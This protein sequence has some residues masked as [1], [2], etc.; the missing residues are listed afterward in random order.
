MFKSKILLKA[1]IVVASV[2]VAYTSAI[3]FFAIPKV[4]DSIRFIEE[5]NAKELLSKV[6]TITKNVQKDLEQY[7][8]SSLEHRKTEL[9]NLTDTTWS[10]ISAKYEQSKPKNIGSV[11]RNKGENFK[12]NLL[13]FYNKNKDKMDEENLKKAILNYVSMHRH[14]NGT[15]YFFVNKGTKTVMHPIKPSL[16]GKDLKNLKD[17]DGIYF[18]RKFA[19]VS[20]NHGDGIVSYKWENPK[21]KL[22]ENK[23]SYIFT[24]EP[25][26]W[27]IGTGEY[28][29]VLKE[30]LQNEVKELVS[31]LRYADNNYFYIS[32]YNSVLIAH[33][34]LKD[35]DMSDIKDKRGNLIVP[36]MVQ[37]A[38]EKGEGFHSYW[39]KKNKEDNTP[40]EKL[41]FSK[42]FPDWNMV[43][44]TGVY[45]DEVENQIKSRKDELIDQLQNIIAT[46]KIGKTGYLY[47][48]DENANM[49]IHPNSNI[50]GKNFA[51]LKNPGKNTYI[52]NDMV[53]AVET[54]RNVIYYKW[55]KPS[56]KG[57]YVYDKVSWVE[58]IPELNWYIASSVYIEDFNESS[59]EVQ[60]FIISI[61]LAIFILTAFFSTMFLKQILEPITKLSQLASRVTNGD[62]SVRCKLT[63][64]DELGNLSQ[65]FNKMIDTTED[66]IDNLDERV[67]EKTNDLEVAKKEVENILSSILL[68][69]LITS[70]K[71]RK[72]LYANKYAEFQYETPLEKLIGENIDDIYTT[73]GQQYHIIKQLREKG[74]VAGLEETFHTASGKQ[75]TALLS[76]TPTTY[77]GEEAYIGMVADITKQKNIENEIKQINKRTKESIEYASLIQTALIPDE[78]KFHKYFD[79]YFTIWQP[80]D[81]VGGDIYLFEELRND[82]ECLLMVI[83]CTGHGVA[84]AF[85]TMLIK[86]LEREIV[87]KIS[88]SDYDV[89]PA[90]I[91]EHFNKTMKKLLQQESDISVSNSG[92]DGGIIYINKRENVLKFAGAYTELFY[93]QNGTINE[94]KGDKHSIGYK[95]SDADFEFTQHIVKLDEDTS[96][97]MTTD[98]FIDQKGGNKGLPFGKNRFKNIIYKNSKG[99]MSL[100]KDVLLKELKSY[101]GDTIT[102]DDITV[103]G[104]EIRK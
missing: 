38:I 10:I 19:A 29:S 61:A 60:N 37:I 45:L 65:E 41:T 53:N 67:K 95:N 100:Q 104:M 62:Y 59:K 58:K 76:V 40:Y 98:G 24:F 78:T 15:G 83:D 13:H 33:P 77:K 103:I 42:N 85:V 57:N 55:D 52:F 63:S 96:F 34:Y 50:N 9:R 69:I 49:L 43:I 20:K 54:G 31:K 101:Q 28:Y 12:S 84:G 56:D 18:I 30:R 47:I 11:L 48:F 74:Y 4:S 64:N 44:G 25:Y 87:T 99:S 81:I 93:I 68:P 8:K 94:I 16:N 22:I 90:I 71:T 32:D 51:K 7:K 27:I 82:D 21:T 46:T 75:F 6:V 17:K 79:D 23:I 2:M 1:M 86:A 89:N 14:N 92:F 35:V 5:K 66:L 91:L 26:E 36:P 3:Y 73:K 97:Y 102:V 88:K 70:K 72:I 80:R 39:W